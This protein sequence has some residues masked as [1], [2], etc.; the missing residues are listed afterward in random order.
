MTPHPSN[1][2]QLQQQQLQTQLKRLKMIQLTANKLR[3]ASLGLHGRKVETKTIKGCFDKFVNKLVKTDE[4]GEGE[5][6]ESKNLSEI[7]PDFGNTN[8]SSS[9]VVFISG[10][11]G[12]GKTALA[13]SIKN[14]V[15][16]R[17][18]IYISGK[19]DIQNR[20]DP[21]LGIISLFREL[22]GEILELRLR[23]K[24]R[25]EALCDA[26]L[27][28]VGDEIVLLAKVV[29]VLKEVIDIPDDMNA[30][31]DQGNKEAKERLKYGFLQFFR[32]ISAHF[33]HL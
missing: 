27:S 15:L 8:T 5:A 7:L 21:F 31:A 25:Y 28:A 30:V 11:S 12:T 16:R 2:P 4:G 22:C 6:V 26:I 1:A 24:D 13:E 18:G 19:F 3:F 29:P 9:E 10:E 20:R 14:V 17:C 23:N 33:D 32:V